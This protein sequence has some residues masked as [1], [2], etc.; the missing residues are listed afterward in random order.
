MP[1]FRDAQ[2]GH[3]RF[4]PWCQNRPS[5]ETSELQDRSKLQ[6]AYSHEKDGLHYKILNEKPSNSECC[7]G[8]RYKGLDVSLYDMQAPCSVAYKRSSPP[9]TFEEAAT[10][11]ALRHVELVLEEH[12]VYVLFRGDGCFKILDDQT[13]DASFYQVVYT[14][15]TDSGIWRIRMPKDAVTRRYLCVTEERKAGVEWKDVKFF[16][17]KNNMEE[18]LITALKFMP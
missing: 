14:A 12:D 1:V 17:A 15:R 10:F 2:T 6:V 11:A 13:A 9:K 18:T 8:F 4:K 7:M 16:K 5:R 3:S